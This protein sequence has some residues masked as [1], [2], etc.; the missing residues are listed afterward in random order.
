MRADYL[1]QLSLIAAGAVITEVVTRLFTALGK[2]AGGLTRRCGRRKKKTP[3]DAGKH[4]E[5]S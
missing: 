5:R 4:F 2:L 3:R 1:E